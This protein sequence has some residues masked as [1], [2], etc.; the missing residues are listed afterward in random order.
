M[1]IHIDVFFYYKAKTPYKKLLRTV[2]KIQVMLFVS[3]LN[4]KA[5]KRKI[6]TQT[7]EKN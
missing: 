3:V 6:S 7:S 2:L 4:D 5:D 1:Y